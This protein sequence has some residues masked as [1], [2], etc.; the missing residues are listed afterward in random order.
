MNCPI[1]KAEM[2]R[3]TVLEQQYSSFRDRLTV[4]WECAC[5]GCGYRVAVK[6]LYRIASE[7]EM[8]VIGG[9]AAAGAD[10]VDDED[11]IEVKEDE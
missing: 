4:V 3:V 1:C 10:E 11:M 2:R 9:V 6:T 8:P 5:P 7:E